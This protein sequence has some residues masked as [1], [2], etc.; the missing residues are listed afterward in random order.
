MP[1]EFIARDLCD[2]DPFDLEHDDRIKIMAHR[3]GVT[4][5]MM[6]ARLCNL[7]YLT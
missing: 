7:G 1:A 5:Q 3:Y 4:E 6:A 2:A